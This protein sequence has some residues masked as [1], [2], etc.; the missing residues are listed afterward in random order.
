V[1]GLFLAFQAQAVTTNPVH[2]SESAVETVRP[3]RSEYMIPEIMKGKL[4]LKAA[5]SK[6]KALP[7]LDELSRAL[8]KKDI[9][10]AKFHLS[11]LKLEHMKEVD[12]SALDTVMAPWLDRS[13]TF[14]EFQAAAAAL[15]DYLQ[16]NG[17]PDANVEISQLQINGDN[18]IALAVNDLNPPVVNVEPTIH[19]SKFK[20]AGV[21]TVSENTLE[22]H[23]EQ[24]SE[25]DLTIKELGTVTE[26]VSQLLRDKGY[27]LSQAYLPPQKIEDGV[28]SIE[29]QEGNVDGSAGQDGLILPDDLKRIKTDKLHA[30][31]SRDV[32]P[33]KP[34][35]VRALE[36]NIRVASD[37][38]GI[39][40][41]QSDLSPGSTP[42]TTKITA[43]VT[44]DNLFTGGIWSDNYGSVYSGEWRVN[45]AVN[46]NSPSGYGEQYFLNTSQASDMESYKLGVHA[47]I[48]R[49]GLRLGTSYALMNVDVGKE[50]AFL[51]LSSKSRVFTLFSNYPIWRGADRNAHIS[52]SYDHKTYEN[53]SNAFAGAME[54]HRVIN[55][56]TVGLSGDMMDRWHGQTQ[57]GL[58]FS[59]ADLDLSGEKNYE[60]ADKY[61][62]RTQGKFYK[63]NGNI[64]RLQALPIIKGL[65][66]Y[67]GYSGQWASDNL[68][69][70]EK[71]QLGGPYGVRAYPVGEA[72]GD[73]GWLAN[74]EIR[75]YL[76]TFKKTDFMLFAFYDKG[77]ITQYVDLWENALPTAPNEYELAGYGGGLSI[78]Y[79]QRGNISL[80]VAA[81]DGDNPNPTS[82]GNDSDGH[83]DD[84]RVWLI[85]KVEF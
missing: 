30:M 82:D 55:S 56:L 70:A 72:V 71:F 35:N 7:N 37:L 69:T 58:R 9:S 48:G 12:F 25:R 32:E 79:D 8:A 84:I 80:V 68:D 36:K 74:F 53:E 40:H 20:V 52:L 13:L 31:L 49:S 85:G 42:G 50:L 67:A 1:C 59:A 10:T 75:Q 73:R 76:G 61:T 33:G 60:W 2:S 22:K 78:T 64:S 16:K 46:L 41:V 81:K 6:K 66:L 83:D 15:V 51:S 44:E 54:N 18:K 21:T 11:A 3:D 45:A 24:W 17:H 65:F 43:H 27:G 34:L 47:P 26:S 39:K 63:I 14:A 57:I 29:V 23:L 38:P 77:G 62:A 19:V 4:V 5:K 28:V